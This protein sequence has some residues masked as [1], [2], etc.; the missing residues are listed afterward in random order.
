REGSSIGVHLVISGSRQNVLRMPLL[1]N[2]KTQ[3]ALYLI[4]ELEVRSIVGRT[5]LE[6]EEIYGRGLIKVE[7]VVSFQTVLPVQG[8]D[9]LEIIEA[10]QQETKEMDEAWDGER[11]EEIP[12]MPE[13]V[14]DFV[15]FKERKQTQKIVEQQTLPLGLEFENVTPLPF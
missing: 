15:A 3:V 2:I 11:P 9:T 7:D 5:Q 12:M 13:D 8:S 1:S 14:I 6:G 4:D 10:I